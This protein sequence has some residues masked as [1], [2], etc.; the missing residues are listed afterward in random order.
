MK[1]ACYAR[2]QK[3]CCPAFGNLL[4]AVPQRYC[5]PPAFVPQANRLKSSRFLPSH[6]EILVKKALRSYPFTEPIMMP[7]RKYL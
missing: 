2:L 4:R 5:D 6:V 7:V 1:K 3:A